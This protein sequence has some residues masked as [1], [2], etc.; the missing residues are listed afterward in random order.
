[1]VCLLA[2]VVACLSGC[3]TGW[4]VSAPVVSQASSPVSPEQVPDG[5]IG[6]IPLP[7]SANAI[8]YAMSGVGLGGRFKAYRLSGDPDELASFCRQHFELQVPRATFVRADDTS[9]DEYVPDG[10]F[11]R[12]NYGVEIG[13]LASFRTESGTVFL[14]SR[15]SDLPVFLLDSKNK[16]LAVIQMD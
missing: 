12:E 4:N 3:E 16:R 14:P 6:A 5:I 15:H 10:D 13:W 9:F 8:Y 7:S 11:V 1:M 2:L